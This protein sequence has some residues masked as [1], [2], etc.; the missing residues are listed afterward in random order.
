[1]TIQQWLQN[2]SQSLKKSGIPSH[3][4]DAGILL[5]YS[6]KKSREYLRAHDDKVLSPAQLTRA[7]ILLKR[8]LN[9]EPLAYILGKKE[10]YGRDFIV[11]PD[12]LIPRPETEAIIELVKKYHIKGRVLD[13]GTGSGC[14]GLTIKAENPAIDL[15]VSDT[16]SE[17]LDI[18]RKNA[19]TLEIKPVR[20]VV[21]NLLEHWLSH[22]KPK[23]F[24]VIVANLP[25]VDREWV[26]SPE[27]AYEPDPALFSSDN[28]LSLVK[29]LIA[30]AAQ[31][32]LVAKGYL[33]LETDIRQHMAVIS[34][35]QEHGFEHIETS[36]LI[37]L[38]RITN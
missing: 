8:R 25:Y 24:D 38:L 30:Q 11:T 37:L 26:V 9:R 33:I 28:G 27:T 2:A 21:S 32:V 13:V 22:Q 10:F 6:I 18:A 35:A 15:I 1:M 3:Q 4:L 12:T 34:Y 16:S 23:P 19:K 7:D 31:H 17:A 14:I 5:S 36:G 20:Y 29:Q